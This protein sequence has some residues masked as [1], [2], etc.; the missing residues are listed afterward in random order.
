MAVSP[1]LASNLTC[2][3]LVGDWTLFR[4]ALLS[5]EGGL[6]LLFPGLPIFLVFAVFP[7]FLPD[8]NDSVAERLLVIG[9]MLVILRQR[10]DGD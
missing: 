7:S 1:S 5:G 6:F 10:E 2:L 3:S 8:E 4:I 9:A